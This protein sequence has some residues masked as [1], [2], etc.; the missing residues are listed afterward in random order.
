MATLNISTLA[1]I[2]TTGVLPVSIELT[3]A[4]GNR[5]A[6]T[7][8]GGV[9]V[10]PTLS[11]TDASGNLSVDLTPN[12]DI[13]PTHTY[14]TIGLG[15]HDFVI[16]KG[17]STESLVDLIPTGTLSPLGSSER[18]RTPIGVLF[19]GQS[20]THGNVTPCQVTGSISGTTLTVSAVT[21]GV[22]E[23]GNAVFGSTT[24]SGTVVTGQIT[25]TGGTGTYT[26]N[27]SQTVSSTILRL[28]TP[29]VFACNSKPGVTAPLLG[30]QNQ[31][32]GGLFRFIDR[33]W[34]YGYDVQVVNGAKGS[35]SLIQHA[36]GQLSAW[37]SLSNSYYAQRQPAGNG[38]RGHFGNVVGPS[39][40]LAWV[41]STGRSR[42][43]MSSGG[44]FKGQGQASSPYVD[45]LQNGTETNATGSSQPNFTTGAA[46]TTLTDGTVVWTSLGSSATTLYGSA[47]TGTVFSEVA[48]GYGWDPLGVLAD[49]FE[50]LQSLPVED[51]FVYID[52][53]QAD[54]SQTSAARQSAVQ[55]VA[56][57]FLDRGCTVLI[58]NMIYSSASG[59]SSLHTTQNA[60][61]LAAAT[62]LA[63]G[64]YAGYVYSGADLYTALGGTNIGANGYMQSDN[65]HLN[66]PGS[67][68]Q[69]DAYADAFEAV[70]GAAGWYP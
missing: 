15:S 8:S 25:G 41:C 53:N 63:A 46:G 66:S 2:G 21:M 28:R 47:T 30:A 42:A 18:I 20:V 9:V 4:Q 50:K 58:G 43:I 55:N 65:I 7:R 51:R 44:P 49:G 29:Q 36:C 10:E 60:A 61:N 26:V 16:S 59:S 38:D 57:F 5:V 48:K 67:I 19:L 64:A 70:L 34:D 31:T 69:G 11:A 32:G 17:S 22:V 54:L 37:A 68:A 35:M 56:S 33:L 6:G 1:A 39:G 12:S 24:S 14:Y 62:A 13:L 52:G 27:H 45:Y 40:S 3:D 23:V